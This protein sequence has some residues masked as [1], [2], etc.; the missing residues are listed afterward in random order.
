HD[1][2]EPR[3]GGIFVEPYLPAHPAPSGAYRQAS[4]T[5]VF[6]DLTCASDALI[7]RGEGQRNRGNTFTLI[8]VKV[9]HARR[10]DI[11]QHLT[12][13]FEGQLLRSAEGS[14]DDTLHGHQRLPHYFRFW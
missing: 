13:C 5:N 12:H 1:L 8:Y 9:V 14:D 6:A 11:D 3:R 10:F 4:Q 7:P 2:R